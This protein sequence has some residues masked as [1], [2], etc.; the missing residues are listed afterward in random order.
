[1]PCRRTLPAGNSSRALSSTVLALPS[2]STALGPGTTAPQ[3]DVAC[4]IK[5]VG[6]AYTSVAARGA[7]R[8]KAAARPESADITPPPFTPA[9][10][11]HTSAAPPRPQHSFCTMASA[12]RGEK[13]WRKKP[14]TSA[15]GRFSS[16]RGSGSPKPSHSR[17]ASCSFSSRNAAACSS[18]ELASA[19]FAHTARICSH[20]PSALPHSSSA[21][22]GANSVTAS[23]SKFF[24]SN[25]SAA[26]CS[27]APTTASAVKL[28]DVGWS[29]RPR[30]PA[31][32]VVME[33]KAATAN[34]TKFV[35]R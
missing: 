22:T 26:F 32:S 21:A 3:R 7:L 24:A 12:A 18:P 25:S 9:T 14:L 16:R 5:L 4:C 19:K 30:R 23:G 6:S 10:T 2:V 20:L 29:A 17:F 28:S 8:L 31:P 15:V 27:A 34:R 1:M 13:L 11:A 35:T 33:L